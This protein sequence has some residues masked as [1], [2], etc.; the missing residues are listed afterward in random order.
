MLREGINEP[1]VRNGMNAALRPE[2]HARIIRK[3]A[4]DF[5][6]AILAAM[7][8]GIRVKM[9]VVPPDGTKGDREW[10]RIGAITRE[11]KL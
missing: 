1:Q 11:E 3:A 8:T 2:D 9:N 4:D 10:L 7:A 5:N 6:H